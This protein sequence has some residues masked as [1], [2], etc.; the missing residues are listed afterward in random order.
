MGWRFSKRVKLLPGLSLNLSKSG[1]STSIGARGAHVTIG[2]G[3]VRQ[4]V[5]IP[6]TGISYTDVQSMQ[7]SSSHTELAP[8][9]TAPAAISSETESGWVTAGKIA[10]KVAYWLTIGI[11]VA[12]AAMLVALLAG[13]TNGKRRR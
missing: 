3:K 11:F 13:S 4:T 2:H 1:V 9:E 5:G 12:F 10:W 7:A 8:L 6:G